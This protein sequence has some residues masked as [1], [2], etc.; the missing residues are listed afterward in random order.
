MQFNTSSSMLSI[1]IAVSRLSVSSVLVLLYA[2]GTLPLPQQNSGSVSQGAFS[3]ASPASQ[4]SS[5]PQ[6]TTA[7]Q[8]TPPVVVNPPHPQSQSTQVA[9]GT[10]TESPSPLPAQPQSQQ[11]PGKTPV[12][13][14]EVKENTA[15]DNSGQP[16]GEN[17]QGASDEPSKGTESAP[18][19]DSQLTKIQDNKI[20]IKSEGNNNGDTATKSGTSAPVTKTQTAEPEK[21]KIETSGGERQ[22]IAHKTQTTRKPKQVDVKP[23][24]VSEAEVKYK[25]AS[26]YYQSNRFQ[27]AIDVLESSDQKE[28]EFPKSKTL[29]LNSY[30]KLSKH[31]ISRNEFVEAK[32]LL[33]KAKRLDPNNKEVES[34]LT[35]VDNILESN[36][37]F[38][39]AV[40]ANNE[41]KLETA[42][43]RF[44]RVLELNP[45]NSEASKYYS[46]LKE[47]V[48]T[49]RHKTALKL[50][51]SQKLNAAIKEWEQLLKLDPNNELAKIYI[52]RAIEM[53]NRI[54]NL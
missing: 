6:V 54:R 22:K 42:F 29:L 46:K 39:L 5:T 35:H 12:S 32:A 24:V 10:E 4:V 33:H 47:T 17:E 23:M 31:M 13:A 43:L 48:I 15:Q 19:L 1:A 45:K 7:A 9:T 44:R 49:N 11:L 37:E 30:L 18:A 14:P 8:T 52:S 28:P 34:N 40:E 26:R 3:P 41:G 2:C 27:N 20:V 38:K 36:K 50:F 25:L 51:R 16:Q 21:G 53:R